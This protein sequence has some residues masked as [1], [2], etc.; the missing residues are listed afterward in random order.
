[1]TVV[2]D[3]GSHDGGQP[4]LVGFV[5][6]RAGQELGGKPVEERRRVVLASLARLFGSEAIRPSA[7]DDQYWVG[8]PSCGGCHGVFPPGLWC[9]AGTALRR[10]H[11]RVHWAGTE[12]ATEW[13]G[14]MEG[15]VR[16]GERAANEVV[17]R[18]GAVG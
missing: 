14:Y 10:P 18:L 3:N 11:R 8:H 4:A 12:T 13:H 1:V 2:F 5:R 6:G 17:A 9:S 16:A 15:A 7:Y